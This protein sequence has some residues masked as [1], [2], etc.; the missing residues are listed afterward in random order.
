MACV[1]FCLLKAQARELAQTVR[2]GT[3]GVILWP[4]VFG[5]P[6][7]ALERLRNVGAFGPE[8]H[9]AGVNWGTWSLPVGV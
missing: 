8:K 7:L 3:K 9:A 5:G 6:A 2:R 1:R 4:W